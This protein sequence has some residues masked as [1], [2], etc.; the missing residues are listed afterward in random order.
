MENLKAF[1]NNEY[2]YSKNKKAYN[3]VLSLY[4]S[5]DFLMKDFKTSDKEFENILLG[6]EKFVNSI[7][8]AELNNFKSTT[9]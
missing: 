4:N 9:Q 5:I 2:H 7:C 3:R 8:V 1:L 6:L